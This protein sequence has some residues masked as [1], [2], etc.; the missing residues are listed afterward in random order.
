MYIFFALILRLLFMKVKTKIQKCAEFFSPMKSCAGKR[1]WCVRSLLL[2]FE[3]VGKKRW[4]N[5]GFC[6]FCFSWCLIIACGV[7]CANFSVDL[8]VIDFPAP[9]Y[10]AGQALV[11]CWNVSKTCLRLN[12]MNRCKIP[13]FLN[14]K[15]PDIL[16]PPCFFP[17]KTLRSIY[18]KCPL[19]HTEIWRYQVVV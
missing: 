15:Q 17:N 5:I 3:T 19:N 18:G 7:I 4:R 11:Y 6:N 10:S 1:Q 13:P 2:S 16:E 9:R 8:R 12:R 14:D